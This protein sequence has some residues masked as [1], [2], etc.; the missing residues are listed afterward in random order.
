MEL[1]HDLWERGVEI[2]YFHASEDKQDTRNSVFS[3]LTN[4]LT[5]FRLDSVIVEKRKTHPVLQRDPG[6]FYTNAFK[7]LLKYVLSGQRDTFNQMIIV[8]DTIPVKNRRRA[9]EKGI[10]KNLAAWAAQHGNKYSILFCASKSE[11][12]LQ[13]VDYLNWAIYRKWERSDRRSY[14][15]IQSCIQSEFDVFQTGTTYFY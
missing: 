3:I 2:E 14:Q 15:L 7:I 13:V 8:C 11:H 6:R 12:N 5:S 4:D 1:K 9:I 10:K